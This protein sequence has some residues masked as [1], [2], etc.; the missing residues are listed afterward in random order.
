MQREDVCASALGS[1]VHREEL[2]RHARTALGAL[3][4]ASRNGQHEHEPVS[5]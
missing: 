5:P 3:S 2:D 1:G 4:A